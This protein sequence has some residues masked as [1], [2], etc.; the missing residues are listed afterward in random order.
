M[1]R[2]VSKRAMLGAGLALGLVGVA[3]AQGPY[4]RRKVRAG[5]KDWDVDAPSSPHALQAGPAWQRFEVRPGDTAPVDRG[6]PARNRAELSSPVRHAPGQPVWFAYSFRIRG[7]AP[8]TAVFSILGQFQSSPDL[9]DAPGLSPVFA[10]NL[11]REGV[12]RFVS[13]SSAEPRQQFN[14]PATVLGEVR[15]VG[16]EQWRHLVGRIVFSHEGRGS[17]EIWLDGRKVID[18]S[19]ISIGYNDRRGPYWKY[20]IY[21]SAAPETLVVE[22]ANMEIGADSL[23]GRI[24]RPL[25]TP[26]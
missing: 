14:P 6:K 8:T 18:R 24:G 23:A 10:V 12:L 1:N 13:R 22:Y 16:R 15:G 17:V 2:R 21:R 4:G 25:P 3:C 19:P 26:A 20:G 5:G 11:V 9:G 7:G